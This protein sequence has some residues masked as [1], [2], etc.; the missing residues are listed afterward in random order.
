MNSY[1]EVVCEVKQLIATKLGHTIE[2]IKPSSLITDL[3]VDSI[4]LFELLIAFEQHYQ[5]QT[6]YEDIAHINTVGD[7]AQYIAHS[8]YQFSCV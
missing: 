2:H 7:I 1:E 6:A 4:Q 3:T 8:K 5:L